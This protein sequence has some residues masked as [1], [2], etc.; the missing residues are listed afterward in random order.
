M[1]NVYLSI[2]KDI[3]VHERESKFWMSKNI[4]S[5]HVTSMIEGI[6]QAANNEFLFI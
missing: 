2:E 4:L 3:A 1:G 5:V 6:E